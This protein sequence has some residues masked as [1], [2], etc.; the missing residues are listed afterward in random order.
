[1]T[2]SNVLYRNLKKSLPVIE[3]GEGIY[4][5]DA[6]GKRYLDAA[7]GAVV[8][9]IGYGRE[10][11]IE[12]MTKQAQKISFAHGSEFTSQPAEELAHE[13]GHLA[14]GDLNRVFFVSGGSEAIESAF[15]LAWQYHFERGH[16]SKRKII[17]LCPSYHGSTLAALSA[18]CREETQWPYHAILMDFP[19]VPA[20]Y[21]ERDPQAAWELER[22]IEEQGEENIAAFI[23]EPIGGASAGAL[24][25]SQEYLRIIRQICDEHDVLLI[26][27]EVMAG[28]GRTGRFFAIEHYDVIPDILVGGKG[29]GSGYIPLGAIIA[30]EEI[31]ETLRK[32][33][34]R[35]VHGFTYQGN[36]LACAVGLEVIKIIQEEDLVHNAQV[37]GAYLLEQLKRL[38]K[39]HELISD[40]RGKG[41]LLALELGRDIATEERPLS[42]ALAEIAFQ[43]GLILYPRNSLE[44]DHLL[45]APPLIIR[46]DEADL[47]LELLEGALVALEERLS[48]AR[49]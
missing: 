27:D 37:M 46:E 23:V 15:K 39:E 41:L 9:N 21:P 6:T 34:G 36:P 44:H 18:T 25:P 10:R 14:P 32:G 1:M 40:V 43:Q 30:R 4:I 2:E 35:F 16:K 8:V 20:P 7:S 47:L 49:R 5:Y 19:K 12:T 38:S 48:L 17:S 45:I 28:F 26:A 31:V 22:V 33:S 24:V 29:L 11:V 13:L 42:M 3:R